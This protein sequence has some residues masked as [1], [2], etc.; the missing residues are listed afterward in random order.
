MI[1]LYRCPKR[2]DGCK[3]IPRRIRTRPNNLIC[4]W[5]VDELPSCHDCWAPTPA[6]VQIPTNTGRPYFV[7]YPHF[8]QH[9]MRNIEGYDFLYGVSSFDLGLRS[10]LLIPE[11]VLHPYWV[12]S[13]S[14]I[15]R[16]GKIFRTTRPSSGSASTG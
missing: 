2:F 8:T 12:E 5:V 16:I 15:K 9:R 1:Y 11:Y 4:T 7:C 6:E 3:K 13:E 10:Y 14:W